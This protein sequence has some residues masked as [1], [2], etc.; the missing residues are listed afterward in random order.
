M[1][2]VDVLGSVLNQGMTP[3]SGKRIENSL[4]QEGGVGIGGILESLG[5]PGG[6][7][8]SGSI[9]DIVGSLG[10]MAGS[11][12][13][14]GPGNTNNPMVTGGLGALAGALLGGGSG[15]VKGA[16]GGSALALLGG[17]AM[18]ALSA[19]KDSL[20]NSE[21]VVAGLRQPQD[22]QEMHEVQTAAEL[23]VRA[24]INAAKADGQGDREEIRRII[25]KASEDGL[26]PEEQAFISDQIR[27]PM[28]TADIVRAVSNKQVA[29][30]VYAASLLAIEVDTDVERRYLSN[31][32]T[33]LR[34]DDSVVDNLHSALGVG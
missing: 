12:M 27:Q 2:F 6:G 9:G 16:V 18:K 17:L 14:S 4:N 19:R 34:L 26:T 30:Q 13:Q 21:Q 8:L 25:G 5:V 15:S 31:L 23:T 20:S 11:A 22:D 28:E 1:N 3:S 7:N 29:A 10:K 33:A 32:A 24:M